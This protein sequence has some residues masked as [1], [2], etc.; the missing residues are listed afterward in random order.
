VG[1]SVGVGVPA[2]PVS[3]SVSVGVGVGVGASVGESSVVEGTVHGVMPVPVELVSVASGAVLLVSVGDG[4]APSSV[5]PADGVLA[6]EVTG[7]V[8][9]AGAEPLG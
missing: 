7:Q 9:V 4:E 2:V 3:V 5:D 6:G 8:T 1:E